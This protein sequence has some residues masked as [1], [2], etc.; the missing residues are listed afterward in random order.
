MILAGSGATRWAA[1]LVADLPSPERAPD[2][3]R[4]AIGEVLSRPEY[5]RPKPGFVQRLQQA[6]ID[7]IERI[8]GALV[9]GGR[10]R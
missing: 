10:G 4:D 3:V 9:G 7:L 6:A 2:E 8:L 5:Q 1:R